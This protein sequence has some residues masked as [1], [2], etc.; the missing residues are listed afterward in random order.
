MSTLDDRCETSGAN[1]EN[2]STT[3]VA[4]SSCLNAGTDGRASSANA[5][6]SGVATKSTT[7]QPPQPCIVTVTGGSR[8]RRDT[9]TRSHIYSTVPERDR[10]CAGRLRCRPAHQLDAKRALGWLHAASRRFPRL[11]QDHDESMVYRLRH[12]ASGSWESSRDAYSLPC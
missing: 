8:T 7:C 9:R 6:A 4:E 11:P 1:L 10:R 12:H 3:D 2:P 5:R